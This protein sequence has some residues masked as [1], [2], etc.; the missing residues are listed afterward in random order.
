MMD[1]YDQQRAYRRWLQAANGDL[2]VV[3]RALIQATREAGDA[4]P[5][6]DAVPA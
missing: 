1:A 4:A 2:S 5:M 3:E 6:F